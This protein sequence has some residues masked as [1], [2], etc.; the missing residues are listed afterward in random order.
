MKIYFML[1][2]VQRNSHHPLIS[3]VISKLSARSFEV[4]T[5]VAESVAISPE[6][7]KVEAD[8][9]ILKSH[10]KL[11]FNVAAVLDAK[12][13][14]ILNPYPACVNTSNK[15]RAAACL[16]AAEVP[17]PRSWVTGD[18][19]HIRELTKAMPLLIKPNLGGNG[20]GIRLV[21]EISELV[22]TQVEDG[23]FVQELVTPVEDEL[24]LYV[25]GD[26]VFGIRKH[27]DD[28]RE[29]IN[30]EPML[31][32]IAIRCG[33]ALGLSIYGVDVVLNANGPIVVDVNYFPSFRGVRDIADTLAD[34][35]AL[36]AL[37]S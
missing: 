27:G 7:L 18:L 11:W 13:A 35:I 28:Y 37:Q 24:K 23:M 4:S 12:G 36:V 14:R 30:V 2:F 19:I 10:S 1:A 21:R 17:L 26:R 3:E 29:N 16:A 32:E 15:I 5:G 8:L 25:I 22:T 9:Y 34:H 31:T 20:L 33:K 6:G